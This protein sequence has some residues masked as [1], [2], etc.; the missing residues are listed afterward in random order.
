MPSRRAHTKSR[1]GCAHCKAKRLKCDET[2]PRCGR[3]TDRD[4]AC[5]YSSPEWSYTVAMVP[6]KRN[7][8]PVLSSKKTVCPESTCQPGLVSADLQ[9]LELM[10]QWCN[11][12]Y[13]SLSRSDSVAWIWRS[14]IPRKAANHPFLMH[15]IL[16]LSALHTAFSS[17]DSERARYLELAQTHHSQAIRG[18]SQL[19][20]LNEANADAAYALSNI[21]IIF[22][23]ALPLCTQPSS[24]CDPIKELLEISQISKG[25][26]KVLMEV[27]HW[28]Q[29]GD[30]A[31][32]VNMQGPPDSPPT[33]RGKYYEQVIHPLEQINQPQFYS[34]TE[35]DPS[36]YSEA[37]H[38]LHMS[39][40][41]MDSQG[42]IGTITA[43]FQ[44]IFRVPCGFLNLI[45]KREPLALVILAS[46]GVMLSQLRAHWWMGDWGNRLVRQ[47]YSIVDGHWKSHSPRIMD[48][49][50]CLY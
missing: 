23:F 49:M 17:I 15:G 37:I 31:A 46:Y 6:R 41:G 21:I 7:P 24:S 28:V 30:L 34:A 12:T 18:L 48:L 39:F 13:L 2:R 10:V 50:N 25:S 4:L 35:S 29:A 45:E 8:S 9:N 27:R 22:T 38:A 32:L 5:S 42:Q 14:V 16:G 43:A 20:H 47:I 44:F 19:E 26:M 11:H 1:H 40:V 3:C 33:Y 36:I